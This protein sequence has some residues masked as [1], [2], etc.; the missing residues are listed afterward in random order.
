MTTSDILYRGRD[1][2]ARRRWADAYAH[3]SDADHEVPLEPDDP[4][5]LATAA[6]LLGREDDSVDI[7][8]R[9][10]HQLLSRGDVARAVRCA[11]W[12]AH[13]LLNSGEHARGGGWIARARRLLDPRSLTCAVRGRPGTSSGHRTKPRALAS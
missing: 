3:L 5:R 10:Y 13:G 8:A 12:L 1:S 4:E 6:Y 2:F 11:F 7:W 9:A